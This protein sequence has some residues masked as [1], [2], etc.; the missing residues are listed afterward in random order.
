MRSYE[1]PFTVQARNENNHSV[2]SHHYPPLANPPTDPLHAITIEIP[3]TS[4]VGL[5]FEAD[6]TRHG[7]LASTRGHKRGE[8]NIFPTQTGELF[9]IKGSKSSLI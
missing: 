6:A 9:N 2:I 8:L 7:E 4:S 1:C 5:L 3:F